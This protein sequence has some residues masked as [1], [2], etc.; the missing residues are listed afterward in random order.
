MTE[1]QG[2]PTV[3]E[4]VGGDSD[5]GGDAAPRGAFRRAVSV[6]IVVLVTIAVLATSLSPVSAQ[7]RPNAPTG[8]RASY[9][10]EAGAVILRWSIPL[11]NEAGPIVG[12]NIDR[13][14][15]YHSTVTASTEFRDDQVEAGQEYRYRVSAFSG[16]PETRTYS[17]GSDEITFTVPATDPGGGSPPS[18][19]P[20][21]DPPPTSPDRCYGPLRADIDDAKAAYSSTCGQTYSDATGHH[22]C[23]WEPGGWRCSGPADDQPDPGDPTSP[24][25]PDGALAGVRRPPPRSGRRR[26]RSRWRLHR[27]LSGGAPTATVVA[28][29]Q[30][31]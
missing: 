7:V 24:Q 3:V 14:G 27:G 26:R 31:P 6:A 23:D 20:T 18:P 13:D 1:D 17:A 15:E 4:S 21:P 28:A 2:S 29:C 16:P 10:S 25:P 19:D 5:D 9:S 30:R 8:L 11:L 12:Y 22:R